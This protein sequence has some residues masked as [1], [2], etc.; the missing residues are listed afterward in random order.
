M[1][2]Q[3]SLAAVAQGLGSCPV[4]AFYDD[5]VNALLGVDG[6]TEGI[7]YMTAVGRPS[8]P[9]GGA[10]GRPAPHRPAEGV[11][12]ARPSGS[13]PYVRPDAASPADVLD[14]RV[15]QVAD[16]PEEAQRGLVVATRSGRR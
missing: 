11:A 12:C 6:E 3:L 7:V 14:L 5:E 15:V 10:D 1:A 16:R 9:F 13:A 2:A 4:A 8:R